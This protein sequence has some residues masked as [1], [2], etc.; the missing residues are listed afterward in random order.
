MCPWIVRARF[1]LGQYSERAARGELQVVVTRRS[2]GTPP[3]RG[4]VPGTATEVLEYSTAQGSRV[5][6]AIQYRRP[7]GTLG[8]SGRP[9]PKWLLDGGEILTPSHGDSSRCPDC[10]TWRPRALTAR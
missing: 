9:D 5:A 4:Q 3:E 8:G 2:K 1:N 6:V 10:P 7:D